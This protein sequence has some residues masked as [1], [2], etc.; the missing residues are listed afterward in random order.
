MKDEKTGQDKEVKV[1]VPVTKT[2]VVPK[3]PPVA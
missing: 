1:K 3:V 2:K